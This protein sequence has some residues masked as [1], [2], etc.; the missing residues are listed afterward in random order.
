MTPISPPPRIDLVGPDF[1]ITR[2]WRDYFSYIATISETVVDQSAAIAALQARPPGHV[3]EDEGIALTQRS[4][5]NF[6][7]AGVTVTDVSGKTQVSILGGGGG[8]SLDDIIA[9]Q[10]LM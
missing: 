4:A 1:K 7:G 5:L 10:A 8:G 9:L 3:I 2:P 6:V